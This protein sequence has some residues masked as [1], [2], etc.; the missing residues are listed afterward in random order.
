MRRLLIL[1]AFVAVQARAD[2]TP[3]ELFRSD[4]TQST[5][6]DA[7]FIYVATGINSTIWRIN[8]STGATRPLVAE[9]SRV[10]SMMS[11]GTT[12]FYINGSNA[13]RAE[14]IVGGQPR[15]LV[16]NDPRTFAAPVSDGTYVYWIVASTP[17]N[18]DLVHNDGEVRRIAIAGGAMEVVATG[19]TLTAPFDLTVDSDFLYILG[20]GR[21]VRLPKGGG[22]PVQIAAGSFTSFAPG[23]PDS[24]W[25]VARQ[26]SELDVWRFVKSASRLE[27]RTSAPTSSPADDASAI[28]GTDG[29]IWTAWSGDQAA[30][31]VTTTF[32]NGTTHQLLNASAGMIAVGP[33]GIFIQSL[34]AIERICESPTRRR[35]SSR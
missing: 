34:G 14:S 28:V 19:L 31:D 8:R 23:P 15:S 7:S 30:G 17:L 1:L 25:F 13:V 24:I 12:L 11:D 32:A 6:V 21:V 27:L 18:G 5:A 29:R 16:A 4:D 26:T 33:D 9:G 3:A 20:G 22:E 35:P 2:C 10:S